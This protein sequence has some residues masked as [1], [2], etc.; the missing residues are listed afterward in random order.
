MVYQYTQVAAQRVVHCMHI[1]ME[2]Q[3]NALDYPVSFCA[4]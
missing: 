2:I 3:V 1:L 4:L